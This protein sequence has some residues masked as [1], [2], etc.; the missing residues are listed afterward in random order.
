[1]EN[2]V[3]GYTVE[4]DGSILFDPSP[5]LD[6]HQEFHLKDSF[7]FAQRI[8]EDLVNHFPYIPI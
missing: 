6:G 3:D 7:Q 4:W 2:G 8:Q 1:M 5:I